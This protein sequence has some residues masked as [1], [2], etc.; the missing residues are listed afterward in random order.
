MENLVQA[1]QLDIIVAGFD[2]LL[3]Y[4]DAMIF[5]KDMNR[6]YV[7][8]SPPFV[9]ITGKT[10]INAIVGH[11]DFEIFQDADLAKRY[12]AD[13]D[14]LLAEGKNLVN[15]VEPITDNQGHPRYSNT[16]KY[17]LRDEDGAAL[18]ILGISRDITREYMA[19]QRYQ[20]ELKYLFEL[21]SD[22]YAALYMDIDDWRVIQHK[23]NEVGMPAVSLQS[24]MEEF[25]SNALLCLV[26]DDVP[27]VYNFYA[28]LSRETMITLSESGRRNYTLEY[29]RK[30]PNGEVIWVHVTIHFLTDPETAH[31]CAIWT[32]E[33]I[34]RQKQETLELQHAAEHDALT[35]LWNRAYMIRQIEEIIESYP[36]AWHALFIIDID[37][38]KQ[39]NDTYGHQ[40]GDK[41]LKELAVILKTSFRDT[42]IVG[43]LGGDEFFVFMRNVSN[44]FAVRE[45]AATIL[46]LCK[47]AASAFM[48]SLSISVGVSMYPKNGN[49]LEALYAQADQALYEAKKQKNTFQFAVEEQ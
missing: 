14:K 5:V 8:A 2:A 39:L 17:I 18:G 12:T 23:R 41:F 13:D 36:D 25:I 44:E 43:R 42:D 22:T 11:S 10:D 27:E 24:T 35:G 31:R 49:S 37:N 6:R 20:Q 15:Y 16:S 3:E 38:F 48:E 7:A 1:K 32:L 46:S 29:P 47:L 40:Q 28:T 4:T 45:K 19:R 33:N 21:P 30:M 34:Q 9:Q 26:K